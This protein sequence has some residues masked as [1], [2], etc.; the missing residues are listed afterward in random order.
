MRASKSG[1]KPLWQMITLFNTWRLKS[2]NQ[3]HFTNSLDFRIQRIQNSLGRYFRRGSPMV[4]VRIFQW[5]ILV[6]IWIILQTRTIF[7]ILIPRFLGYFSLSAFNL[8]LFLQGHEIF[9]F[10]SC[11]QLIFM[12]TL[13]TLLGFLLFF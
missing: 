8:I 13:E 7:F 1:P 2:W 12:A 4:E 3:F 11:I 6:P 5:N 10:N 9:K